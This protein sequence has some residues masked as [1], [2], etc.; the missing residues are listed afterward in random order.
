M[1]STQAL[2]SSPH[3]LQLGIALVCGAKSSED[4][5]VASDK[6]EYLNKIKQKLKSTLEKPEFSVEKAKRTR[7]VG[8]RC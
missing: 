2:H 7:A 6:V 3:L 1:S 8:D 5:K 4:L